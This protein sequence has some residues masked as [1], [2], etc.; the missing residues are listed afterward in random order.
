[1]VTCRFP[2]KPHT[3]RKWVDMKVRQ[4]IKLIQDD[5][6]FLVGCEAAI[7]SLNTRQN[8]EP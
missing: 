6:W 3:I 8:P 5:G 1:M 7:V 2:L 4:L